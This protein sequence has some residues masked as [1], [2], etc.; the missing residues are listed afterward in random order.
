MILHG[1]VFLALQGLIL[2]V[3]V[4][5]YLQSGRLW[6]S[7][8]HWQVTA[9]E[10]QRR[11]WWHAE[12]NRELKQALQAEKIRVAQLQHRLDELRTQA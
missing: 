12:E 9:R 8:D 11:E 3:L 2:L 4:V 5:Q 10:R 7:L 1:W 6:R